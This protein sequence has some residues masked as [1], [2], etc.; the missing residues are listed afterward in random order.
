[1]KKHLKH[2]NI[3]ILPE[4]ELDKALMSLNIQFKF[5]GANLAP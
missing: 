1:M 3:S 4:N 2:K 5:Q